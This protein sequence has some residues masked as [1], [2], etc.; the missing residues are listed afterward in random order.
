MSERHEPRSLAIQI[1]A[2]R[3]IRSSKEDL[4]GRCTFAESLAT[5]ISNWNGSESLVVAL[6]GA[7]GSGKSSIKNMVVEALG[8]LT[9][10]QRPTIIEF[11]PWQFSGQ[12]GLLEAFFRETG[13]VLGIEDNSRAG[14]KLAAKWRSLSAFF[15]VVRYASEA[16]KTIVEV[17]IYIL[18][19]ITLG[20]FTGSYIASLLGFI[21]FAG[22]VKGSANVS[23]WVSST[24]EAIAN[25]TT[26]RVEAQRKTLEERKQELSDLLKKRARPLL[27]ILDDI[28]RL[29]AMEIQLIFRVVKANLDF[30]NV[31]Y[32]LLFQRESVEEALK[33][34]SGVS[35]RDF[36]EK[37]VQAGFD[38]PVVEQQ[39]LEKVL[40]SGL[41]GLLA[42]S[43]AGSTFDRKRWENIFLA[44]LRPY[45]ETLRD[46]Y[47]FLSTLRFHV[48]VLN[49]KAS[50][51]VNIVD[52]IAIEVLR[53]F[54]PEVYYELRNA[55]G[56]LTGRAQL[57]KM[58][59]L[60]KDTN[61]YV[62]KVVEHLVKLASRDHEPFVQEILKQLFP[63]IEWVYGGSHYSDGSF[64]D[65]WYQDRRICSCDVFERYFVLGIPHG[66]VS[67]S[68]LQRVLDNAGNRKEL[69]AAL[70]SFSEQGRLATLLDRLDSYKQKVDI[71]HAE[72]FV[73]SLFD[74]GDQLPERPVDFFT[75]APDIYASRIIYWYLRQ[76]PDIARRGKILCSAIELTTGLYLPTYVVSQ[77]G[78]QKK[79]A[80]RLTSDED[81]AVLRDLCLGKI[82]N[83]AETGDLVKNSNLLFILYEWKRLA[84]D[85]EVKG[86]VE[87]L[88]KSGGVLDF[89]KATLHKT[90]SRGIADYSSQITERIPAKYV[91]DFI[92][93]ER[94]DEAIARLTGVPDDERKRLALEAW[95]KTWERKKAGRKEGG[96]LDLEDGD[97]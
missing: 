37:I 74:I 45:F 25:W 16:T 57:Y 29:T 77:E 80:E 18:P 67:H 61:D 71:I 64:Q 60:E 26:A 43:G 17:L 47:R 44:G 38:I 35:G 36:L 97:D 95:K 30:P 19:P 88:I 9:E 94:I 7:W 92:P 58:K 28:D 50:F 72:P 12:T 11:N 3:P 73:T 96:P 6:Y 14:Q 62:R 54:E 42:D 86:W 76:E 1:L 51:E 81:L 46:V 13:K 63:P 75:I 4:L 66:D 5:A 10:K 15:R 2:D 33:T 22:L 48:G 23:D 24:S 83:G 56:E 8:N 91:E 82:R 59:G 39:R 70:Q 40:F 84:G 65:R 31:A 68:D 53:T 20:T 90:A 27:I 55:K 34:I 85:E 41:D 49:G 87:G 52:L 89:L 21:A 93:L 78:A 79:F 69:V 32:L